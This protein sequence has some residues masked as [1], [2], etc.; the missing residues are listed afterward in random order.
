M[1]RVLVTGGAG[2]IG[3]HVVER[4]VEQ[5]FD[6]VVL[7][8]FSTGREENLASVIDRITL[9]RG[10]ILDERALRE[11][12]SNV[13][14]VIHLAA[15]ISVEESMRDPQ[16]YYKVNVEGTR[17]LLEEARGKINLL[18]FMSS[19]AVYGSPIQL[20]IRESHPLRPLSPYGETKVL[21]ERIME[22][23]A[24]ENQAVAVILRLFNA[25]GPRQEGNPYA[26]VVAKFLERISRRLP[27][28]IYGDGFQ[29][30]D[31][32]NV[33]DVASLI[34]HVLIKPPQEGGARIYN[35]GT[36]RETRIIDLAKLMASLA[37]LN[38]EPIHKPAREGDIR[39]SVACIE[40]IRVETGW[41]PQIDLPKGLR[42]LLQP[43]S[44]QNPP[45]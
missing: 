37:G 1:K 34:A 38:V 14:A 43:L 45:Y 2:F 28:V 44:T 42:G 23:W 40:K 24:R 8:D 11:A 12:L 25:Y 15:R 9:I 30:R 26:G 3:S 21:G 19:A 6:V 16:L 33:R 7:D 39:R 32:I 18:V 22:K 41:K 27:P 4:L 29:T 35:L 31:F 10:S 13:E 5:E 36:G 20:P 17:R